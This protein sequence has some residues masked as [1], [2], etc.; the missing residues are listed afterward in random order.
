MIKL[1]TTSRRFH[2]LEDDLDINA[3]RLLEGVSL[4]QLRDETL[5]YVTHVAE[6]L[7]TKGERAKHSQVLPRE[8]YVVDAN[9]AQLGPSRQPRPFS[10]HSRGGRIHD[11]EEAELPS[12]A[13][14][15]ASAHYSRGEDSGVVDRGDGGISD[16]SVFESDRG[17]IGAGDS[18][19]YSRGEGVCGSVEPHR[20]M[21]GRI[22]RFGVGGIVNV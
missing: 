15:G 19:E 6:G 11:A 12:A 16:E 10:R 8:S 20:G 9:L 21:C 14:H 13:V 22:R 4:E 3:G 18:K 7:R 5:V 17:D 1:L 2:R